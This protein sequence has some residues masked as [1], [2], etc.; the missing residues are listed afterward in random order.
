MNELTGVID[1]Y[2]KYDY[3][4]KNVKSKREESYVNKYH[5][6]IVGSR[7]T[8]G[9][10]EVGFKGAILLEVF[11]LEDTPWRNWYYTSPIESFQTDGENLVIETLNSTYVLEKIW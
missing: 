2:D 4:L 11:N 8:P 3:V 7:C 1:L 10:L 5:E 9:V 6:R